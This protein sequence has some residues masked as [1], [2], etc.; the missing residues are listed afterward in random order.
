MQLAEEA[1]VPMA[2]FVAGGALAEPWGIAMG[3]ADAGTDRPLTVDTPFRIA[4][5]TKTFVAAAILCLWEE[6]LLEL[7]RPINS[8][9]SSDHSSILQDA[10]YAADRIT[11]RNLLGHSS[12]LY[13]HADDAFIQEVISQPQRIWTRQEQI[14][15]AVSSA[16]PVRAVGDGFAYSDTGY[17][18]LGEIIENVTGKSLAQAARQ[19]LGFDALGASSTWWENAEHQPDGALPRARQYLGPIDASDFHPSMDSFGGGGLIMSA[20]DLSNWTAHLFEG[21]VYKD[22][23]TLRVMMSTG[24]HLNAENYRLGLMHR[25]VSSFD[26]Y[27]HLG[28]WGSAA[29]YCPASKLSVAGFTTNREHRGQLVALIEQIICSSANP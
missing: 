10:G 1:A 11:V 29:Y 16:R 4:S 21:R 6:D 15:R 19:L 25:S 28:F 22:P 2:V 9:I 7:D 23:S 8:Y 24:S 5:N 3:M 17:I 18:L 13:D 12:G 27:F 14:R 26:V 20:R